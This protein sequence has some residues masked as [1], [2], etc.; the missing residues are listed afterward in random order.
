[1]PNLPVVQPAKDA[2]QPRRLESCSM[3]PL[4]PI[5]KALQRNITAGKAEAETREASSQGLV[6]CNLRDFIFKKR[7]HLFT[8]SNWEAV[9]GNDK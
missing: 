9:Y 4:N 1:M 8:Y 2:M 5:Y 6:I 7:D 3:N